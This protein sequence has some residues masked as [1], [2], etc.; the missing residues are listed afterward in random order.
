[1]K[2]LI[3]VL[4]L[5]VCSLSLS[6]TRP[7]ASPA[8]EAAVKKVKG[9]VLVIANCAGVSVDIDGSPCGHAPVQV[10]EL[11]IGR[12][13]VK[14]SRENYLE[15]RKTVVIKAGKTT[16]LKV[17]M[18]E[19]AYLHFGNL[20][21]I[22][23]M[24]LNGIKISPAPGE[25]ITIRPGSHAV[26]FKNPAHQLVKQ[27]LKLGPGESRIL[28]LDTRPKTRR[29]AIFKSMILPGWGQHYAGKSALSVLYPILQVG[30]LSGVL[31]TINHYNNR[32][33]E[34]DQSRDAYLSARDVADLESARISMF[35]K[36]DDIE[37]AQKQCTL[38]IAAAAGLWIWNVLDAVIWPPAQRKILQLRPTDQSGLHP[39]LLPDQRTARVGL[40]WRF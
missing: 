14:L 32:V 26:V 19:Y 13:T 12:H 2:Y 30:A 31:Y 11:E 24:G 38:M 25:K 18:T 17:T 39:F 16:T 7:V 23:E 34:Y 1:M 40:C 27:S 4:I 20:P 29:S 10:D 8:P 36:Y 6:Q 21:G 5:L 33:E 35:K 15:Q 28:E 9:S 22:S 37:N 3:H